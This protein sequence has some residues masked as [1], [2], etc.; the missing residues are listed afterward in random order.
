MIFGNDRGRSLF[1]ILS[2]ASIC[3]AAPAQLRPELS[4]LLTDS[5]GQ[6]SGRAAD[7]RRS[8]AHHGKRRQ[9]A[10][11]IEPLLIKR[12]SIA[13]CLLFASILAATTCLSCGARELLPLRAIL[14]TCLLIS[15]SPRGEWQQTN[16]PVQFPSGLCIVFPDTPSN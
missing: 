11:A 1:I 15:R 10:R 12:W 3:R 5:G 6:A 2:A 16:A 4:P 9:A 8:A 7:A 13:L 14:K